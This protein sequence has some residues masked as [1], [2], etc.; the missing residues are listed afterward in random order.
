MIFLRN[1]EARMYGLGLS[2]QGP[3]TAEAVPAR[4]LANYR[5]IRTQKIAAARL[6]EFVRSTVLSLWMFRAIQILQCALER[7][8]NFQKMSAHH[9]SQIQNVSINSLNYIKCTLVRVLFKTHIS[10]LAIYTYVW[11]K[12]SRGSYEGWWEPYVL[13]DVENSL[14]ID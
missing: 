4:R 8:T 14:Y 2:S 9:S 6:H 13:L 1:L 10:H 3:R 12:Y 11:I 5:V 7:Q